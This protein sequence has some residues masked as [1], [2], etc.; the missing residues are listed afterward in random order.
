MHN[1]ISLVF[2][3]VFQTDIR[4]K[5]APPRRGK[6]KVNWRGGLAAPPFYGIIGP[7]TRDTFWSNILFKNQSKKDKK[8]SRPKLWQL[9][10]FHLFAIYLWYIVM[11]FSY[12]FT[13]FIFIL[14]LT[15]FYTFFIHVYTFIT[16]FYTYF[17]HHYV[18]AFSWRADCLIA[19]V[20]GLGNVDLHLISEKFA[21]LIFL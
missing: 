20:D 2:A 13:F 11:Y 15:H 8:K 21:P 3:L 16:H 4:P 14:I 1:F 5:Y 18:H 19:K 17:I 10:Y 9:S 12:I 6:Y 7:S